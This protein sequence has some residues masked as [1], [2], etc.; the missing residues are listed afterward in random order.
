VNR[1][2][3]PRVAIVSDPLVQRGGAEKI[4]ADVLARIFPDAPIYAILYSSVTGPSHIAHR[5]I[6][7]QLQRIPG[8]TR[9]HRWLL[10]LYPAAV[11]SI[12]LRG[13]DLIISSHHTAAKGILRSSDQRHICYCYTPMRALWERTFEELEELPAVLR[14]IAARSLSRLREWDYNTAGRVDMFLAI[15]ATTRD[16]ISRHY[17]RDSRIVYPAV[18][19]ERFSLDSSV[20]HGDYYLVASRLVPYKRVDIAVGAAA[21]LGRRLVVV[22]T[23]PDKTRLVD[24]NCEYLG[25]VSEDRL[26]ELIRG[27]RALLF[28]ALE[29]FG[30]TPVEVMSCGRP[31]IAFG[32]GGA[33]D[34]VVDG[35]SGIFAAEQT[36]DAFADAILRF[37]SLTFHSREIAMQVKKFSFARFEAQIKEAVSE[38]MESL[39]AFA[40]EESL[41]RSSHSGVLDRHARQMLTS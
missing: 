21:K 18:D 19:L 39:P 4:V 35:V 37:E 24:A 32:K 17:G 12:D 1:K 23:G 10:P 20:V 31:V 6:P 34:T 27:C 30:I 28:P 3:S 11:E 16:R 22:G 7:T 8:A 41:A 14:P 5:V 9:R 33:L 13:F 25:H 38:V 29:D 2:R 26:I 36:I 15:S 40:M